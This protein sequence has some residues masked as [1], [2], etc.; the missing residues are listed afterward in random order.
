[1]NEFR[2]KIRSRLNELTASE[3]RIKDARAKNPPFNMVVTTVST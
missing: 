3:K 1:M 2:S